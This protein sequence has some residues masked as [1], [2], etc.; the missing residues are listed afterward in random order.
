[1][2]NINNVPTAYEGREA[3]LFVSYAHKDAARV[4]PLLWRMQRTGLR[5]W[6]DKGIEAGAEWPETVESHLINAECIVVFLS[7]AAVSSLNCRNEINLALL[8]KK[9]I[10]VVYLEETQLRHGMK[11]QLNSVQS[12]SLR[13]ER[14]GDRQVRELCELSLLSPCRED[15]APKECAVIAQARGDGAVVS[16]LKAKMRQCGEAEWIMAS[17]R[18]M[19]SAS[20]FSLAP[21]G[22]GVCVSQLN[23]FVLAWWHF[24]KIVEKANALG[25][26]M[27]RADDATMR[28]GRLG[29]EVSLDSMEGFIAAELLGAKEGSAVTRR[30]T[31]YSGILAWAG[32][33]SLHKSEGAGSYI[34]VNEAFRST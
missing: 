32:I 15:A 12:I 5:V 11:L 4:L 18:R 28:S 9:K 22:E 16:A 19:K 30:S 10:L 1:M 29:A 34:T 17:L 23:G 6:F 27:Y 26:I 24:E 33:V 31:Y 7:E 20:T 21:N 2:E 14:D 13:Q 3:Y 25:G 8:E